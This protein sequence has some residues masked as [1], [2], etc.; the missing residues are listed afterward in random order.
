MA[1]TR[2][3]A[4]EYLVSHGMKPS[5]NLIREYTLYRERAGRVI[6]R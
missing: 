4:E 6:K 2:K 5:E 1:R 3:E